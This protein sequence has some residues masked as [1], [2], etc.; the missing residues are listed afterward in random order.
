MVVNPM[1]V[2][3]ALEQVHRIMVDAIHRK[4]H[5]ICPRQR[6]SEHALAILNAAV[7]HD[8]ITSRQFHQLP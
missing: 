5:Y 4:N 8:E 3:H 6:G 7:M 1:P 2:A